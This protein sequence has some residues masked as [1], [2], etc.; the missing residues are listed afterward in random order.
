MSAASM[1][2]NVH[3]TEWKFSIWHN[4]YWSLGFTGFGVSE[5]GWGFGASKTDV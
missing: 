1:A 3:C 2:S 5:Q 4:M